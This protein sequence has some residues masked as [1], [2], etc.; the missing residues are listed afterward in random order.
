[1]N[2]I[3]TFGSLS[4]ADPHSKLNLRATQTPSGQQQADDSGVAATSEVKVERQAV[5][6]S[7]EAFSQYRD[8]MLATNL[9][10]KPVVLTAEEMH[11]SFMELLAEKFKKMDEASSALHAI[12]QKI[13]Q[14]YQSFM[15]N[16]VKD[17]PDL[18][19]ASFGFTVSQYGR[20]LVTKTQGLNQE[21]VTRLEQAL[22]SSRELVEQANKLA[23]AQI[24]VFDAEDFDLGVSFNRDNYAQTID[25]GAEIM[26]R[27]LARVTPHDDSGREIHQRSWDNN[28]RQQLLTN[29]VPK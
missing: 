10:S 12:S 24:A 20:L 19:E 26:T 23:N 3:P 2:T 15:D 13:D 6:I 5:T 29:G 18:K 27:N 7:I 22:N 17:N 21:Q 9:V 28:W 11:T 25:I 8:E 4:I 1:M 14:T 16:L